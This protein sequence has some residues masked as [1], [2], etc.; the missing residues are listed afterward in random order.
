MSKIAIA[1]TNEISHED[2][3]KLRQRGIGGSDCAAACG[4]SRWKSRLMLYLEKTSSEVQEAKTEYAYWGTV[5]E[6]ILRQEFAKRTGF[7]VQEIPFMFACREYP[8]MLA[9]IDGLV[10]EPDGTKALLEIKTANGFKAKEWEDGLP[11][12]Y[13][14]QIQH[15]IL[16]TDL[17]KAWVAVLIGGNDFRYF[18][19]ERDEETIQMMIALEA[20]FWNC[21]EQGTQP[22]IDEQSAD[23]LAVL[24]PKNDSKSSIILPEEA[25]NIIAGHR[26]IMTVLNQLKPELEKYENQ[27]KAMMKTASCA[28][29]PQGY[30]VKWQTTSSTR[31][32]TFKLKKERPEIAAEFSVQTS[33]RRFSI[34]EPKA[35]SEATSKAS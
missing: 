4:L 6:P 24:Y 7:T 13:Y 17:P 18:P 25:D 9:N 15:Y 34:T 2:W 28:K 30:T 21:V 10:T 27:L 12:E 31:I 14:L 32:D 20:E 26:E 19:V 5:M 11:Q 3:L 35:E 23:G 16:V 33:S 29:T 8:F 22:P 1:K